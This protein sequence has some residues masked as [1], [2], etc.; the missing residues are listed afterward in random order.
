LASR[1][2]IYADCFT[3]IPKVGS[4][5]R[6]TTSQQDVSLVPV[7]DISRQTYQAQTVIIKGLRV[8]NNLG[9]QADEQQVEMSYPDALNYQ[10]ALTWPQALLQGRLD[11][12]SVRRDRYFATAWGNG[13]AG[14]TDWL[15]GCP[16]FLG[17]MSSLDKVGRQSATLNVKSNLILLNRDTP[18]F[19]WE[20]NC[21][22]TWGDLACGVVQADWAAAA[23]VGASPSSSVIPWSGA[24]PAYNLGKIHIEN[25]DSVTRVRTIARATSSQLYLAYPLDFTPSVAASFLAYPGCTRTDDATYGCP[26]YHGVD[27]VKKFKGFP[28]IPVAEAGI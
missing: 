12:A 21:K 4:P 23:T 9:V 27:W 3:F 11:G 1:Q 20:P 13:L 17:L 7:D 19:L 28:F 24:G 2:F 18:A 26:K 25:G 14:A 16:M 8:R 6:Y 10:A 22:N 5:L 15:G